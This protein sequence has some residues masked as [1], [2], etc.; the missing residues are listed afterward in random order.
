M[1][2]IVERRLSNKKKEVADIT[3]QIETEQISASKTEKESISDIVKTISRH[4]FNELNDPESN[5]EELDEKIKQM[6]YMTLKME[7]Y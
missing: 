2:T 7:D 4:F 5:K 3:K 6:I 1:P